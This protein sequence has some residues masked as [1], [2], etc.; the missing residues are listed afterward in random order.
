VSTPAVRAQET[1]AKKE[2]ESADAAPQES[3]LPADAGG[4]KPIWTLGFKCE[5]LRMVTPRAG[6]GKG[7]TYWY[8]VYTLE[9]STGEEREFNLSISA[10]SDRGKT[11]SDIFLP[12]VE[13]EIERQERVDLWGRTDLFK[14][15][16]ERDPSDEKYGYTP[17]KDGEKRR[18]VA[19]FNALDRNANKIQITVVGLSNDVEPVT[20]ADG[21]LEL[22]QRARRLEFHRAGDEYEVTLDSIEAK[23]AEWTTV[24]SKVDAAAKP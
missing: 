8:M 6:S 13:R 7:K 12:S 9:N 11:Y 20:Q 14:L 17:I 21:S 22:R 2:A 10:A 3:S 15:L 19:V 18:C 23:K 5:K 24:T 16:A 1:P 4:A